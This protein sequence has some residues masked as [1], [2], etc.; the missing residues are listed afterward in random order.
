MHRCGTTHADV[1]SQEAIA[2]IKLMLDTRKT[3]ETMIKRIESERER[4]QFSLR[5]SFSFIHLLVHRQKQT[6]CHLFFTLPFIYHSVLDSQIFLRADIYPD[7]FWIRNL[8]SISLSHISA[9]CWFWF[10]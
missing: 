4:F 2:S 7:L 5:G 9:L 6:I 8:G 10:E 1:T 3:L